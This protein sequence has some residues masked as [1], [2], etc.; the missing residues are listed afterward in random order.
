MSS[1]LVVS[2]VGCSGREKSSTPSGGTNIGLSVTLPLQ[3]R[4][5]SNCISTFYTSIGTHVKETST[6]MYLDFFL[7]FA[8]TMIAEMIRINSINN[9]S[10]PIIPPIINPAEHE[11]E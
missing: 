11:S 8:A 5:N 1:S 9:I 10:A 7:F 6:E 4:T 3:Y 2:L